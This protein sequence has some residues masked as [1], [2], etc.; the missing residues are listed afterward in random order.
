[1][2]FTSLTKDR[3]NRFERPLKVVKFIIGTDGPGI[4]CIMETKTDANGRGSCLAVHPD[5]VY[6]TIIVTVLC[7]A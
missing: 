3:P 2:S 6:F 5:I 4:L 7:M 1:M